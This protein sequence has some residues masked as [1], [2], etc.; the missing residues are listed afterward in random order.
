MG[1]LGSRHLLAGDLMKVRQPASAS[2]SSSGK[3]IIKPASQ[4]FREADTW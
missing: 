1:R 4:G 3:W 2:V